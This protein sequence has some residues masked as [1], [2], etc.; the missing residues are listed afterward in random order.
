[1]KVGHADSASR[2]VLRRTY[3]AS[4]NRVFRAC[5][6]AEEIVQWMSPSEGGSAEF[7]GMGLRTGG[8]YRIGYRTPNGLAVVGGVFLKVVVP[9][10]LVYTWVW[11]EPEENA[12]AETRVTVEFLEKGGETELVLTHE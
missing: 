9:E 1:M 6:D 4:R 8:P 10:K 2:V 3:A 5:T 12:G 11:E 7:A